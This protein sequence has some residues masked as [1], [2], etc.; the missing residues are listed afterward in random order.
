MASRSGWDLAA[1]QGAPGPLV[2]HVLLGPLSSVR[3]TRLASAGEEQRA[4]TGE[5]SGRR[6]GGRSTG[7]HGGG[8]ADDSRERGD[9]RRRKGGEYV[10]GR[11][12]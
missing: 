12:N 10:W 8:G 7:E 2:T 5:E 3:G 6:E 1:L 9:A 4:A 11:V